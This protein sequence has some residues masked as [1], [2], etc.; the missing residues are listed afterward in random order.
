MKRRLSAVAA[1]F[2]VDD[3]IEFFLHQH[4]RDDSHKDREDET[5][6]RQI[7]ADAARRRQ[8]VDSPCALINPVNQIKRDEHAEQQLIGRVA[9][10]FPFDSVQISGSTVNPDEIPDAE[11]E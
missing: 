7:A 11:G 8:S 10:F 3:G 2:D 1:G 5:Q 4:R 6:Y 9:V